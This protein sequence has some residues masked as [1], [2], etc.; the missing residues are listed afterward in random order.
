[1]IKPPQSQCGQRYNSYVTKTVECGLLSTR[2]SIQ[3]YNVEI[4][5]ILSN[6]NMSNHHAPQH[7]YNFAEQPTVGISVDHM[8]LEL[9]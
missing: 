9:K 8:E 6:L 3:H 1:M 7:G 5:N 2:T 4:L